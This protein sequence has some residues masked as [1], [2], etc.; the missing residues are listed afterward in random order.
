MDPSHLPRIFFEGGSWLLWNAD[1]VTTLRSTAKVLGTPSMTSP[2]FPQQSTFLCLP[3]ELMSCESRWCQEH[4]FCTL[5]LPRFHHFETDVPPDLPTTYSGRISVDCESEYDVEEAPIPDVPELL[6]AVYSDLKARGFWVCDGNH[7]GADFAIYRT[8]P[9]SDHSIALV[10]C[11]ESD[12]DVR[13][14][15]QYVRIAESAKKNAVMA[16]GGSMGV[17]YINISRVKSERE[18][19]GEEKEASDSE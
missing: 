2:A 17:R 13:K 4:G 16:V 14:L 7:Y 3:V 15:V 6:Y 18:S 19:L 11:Q 5:V 1:D 9:G 10:W 12:V 8:S